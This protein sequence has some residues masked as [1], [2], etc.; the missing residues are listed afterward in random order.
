MYVYQIAHTLLADT[1][2]S[3]RIGEVCGQCF[4]STDGV[5]QGDSFSLVAF[6]A[7]FEKALQ[8]VR[9]M[10]PATPSLD[11]QLSLVSEM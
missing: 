11:L 6:T 4:R 5:P 2:L 7:T 3:V 8:E 10:F 1:S 9:P